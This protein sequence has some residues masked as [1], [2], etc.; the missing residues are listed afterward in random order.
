MSQTQRTIG[1][2]IF[3]LDILGCT[4]CTAIMEAELRRLAGIVSVELNNVTGTLR[5]NFDP[6]KT[7]SEAI[8][9][10]LTELCQVKST[11]QIAGGHPKPRRAN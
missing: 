7:T 6:S 11:T 5:V 1:E 10:Y 9:Y 2:A 8:R 3:S 4:H